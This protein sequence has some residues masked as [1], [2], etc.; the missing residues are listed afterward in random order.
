VVFDGF[1][2]VMEPTFAAQRVPESTL[3]LRGLDASCLMHLE[4]RLRT[5]QD[6][7]DSTIV[8]TIFQDYGFAVDVDDEGPTRHARVGSM[9]Q[10][11]TDAEFVRQLARRH[12]W[13]CNLRP[14]ASARPTSDAHPGTQVVGH[15][16]PP[17]VGE[18]QAALSLEPHDAPSLIELRA[19]WDSHRPTRIDGWHIDARSRRMQT[20]TWPRA[21]GSRPH[22]PKQGR[23]SRQELL[24]E[25]LSL[26]TRSRSLIP[27]GFQASLVPHDAAELGQLAWADH[28]ETDWL[29]EADGVVQGLRYDNI[30]Q[31]GRSVPIQ[32]GGELIN[33]D[34]YVRSA[35]HRWEAGQA[36]QAYEIDVHLL[37]N[38][39]GEVV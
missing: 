36:T 32:G 20:A 30:L 15:F 10:R 39:I 29:A 38:A 22:V 25:R 14:A 27:R 24:S 18:T 34:W 37:R 5:W 1:I 6:V 21:D 12:G 3:E 33:G 19:R 28:L 31:P 23:Y 7:A 17:R 35:R 4:A 13:E 26:L 9:H 16:H 8:S 2:T 11:C